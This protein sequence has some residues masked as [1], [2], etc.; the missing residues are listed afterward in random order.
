[1]LEVEWE[2][3]DAEATAEVERKFRNNVLDGDPLRDGFPKEVYHLRTGTVL[4][5]G[6]QPESGS[7][8]SHASGRVTTVRT[9]RGW[10][11]LVLCHDD[12][13]I[14]EKEAIGLQR[15]KTET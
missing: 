1:M 9:K 10:F 14:I 6:F 3:F 4:E 8:D 2:E 11:A 13:K 5:Y 12:G 15:R 7:I